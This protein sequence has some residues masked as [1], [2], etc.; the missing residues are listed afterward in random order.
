MLIW[1]AIETGS[2]AKDEFTREA[3][4]GEG[5]EL[6]AAAAAAFPENRIIGMYLDS[7]IPWSWENQA[8][9]EAPDWANLEREGLEKLADILDF[10][11]DQRQAPDGQY[12]GGWGD[13]VEMW[14]SWTPILVGFN[15]PKVRAAEELLASG[16]FELPRMAE[17]YTSIMTDVEH[18]AEDSGDTVT[19]MMHIDPA[20]DVWTAR[21]YRLAELMSELWTGENDRSQLQFKS[22][23]FTSGEVSDSDRYACDTVYHPRAVQP[24]LLL[25]QRTGD[26]QLADLFGAW[27][28]TWVA[29]AAVEERGKPAGLLPSAI[30]WPS[31]EIGGPKDKWWEPGCASNANDFE[32]P[33]AMSLMTRSLLLTGY[34]TGDESYFD[35]IG[36]MADLREAYLADPP[37]DPEEGGAMWAAEKMGGVL[38]QTLGKYRLLTG[39]DTYDTLL[40]SGTG[41]Y[42]RYRLSGEIQPLIDDL[43]GAIEAFR[44][45]RE[46][47]TVET[48]F[49]DRIFKF[50]KG[51]AN[52]YAE[53][54]LERPDTA[55]LYRMVT[56]DFGDP[57][58]LPLNAV[59][60]NTDPRD[61]AVLVTDHDS[62]HLSADLFHF[63]DSER[64]MGADLLMLDPGS[65]VWRLVCSGEMKTD[66]SMEV[67][68]SVSKIDFT[69]PTQSL[70]TLTIEAQ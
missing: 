40:L 21:A 43:E 59:R 55:L 66:G 12:G 1:Q 15:D 17:G 3:F 6:L 27:M 41:G 4:F 29:A 10:W 49:T 35:P 67:V 36:S 32:W 48:R 8:D 38:N 23:T 14:R 63:G 7:P 30:H 56:G 42:V 53:T 45:N 50:H 62:T 26:P 33:S 20:S 58:Y 46:G 2:L 24:A 37:A 19:A 16:L 28:D 68:S 25:W 5:R 64:E 34:M 47:Y 22:T 70:C 54:P 44:V 61:I 13:D 57:L 9:N 51:Y 31:G 18:S 69:L 39:K 60:W 65:Y 11:I 52:Y